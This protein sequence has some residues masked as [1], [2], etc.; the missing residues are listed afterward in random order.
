MEDKRIKLSKPKFPIVSYLLMIIFIPSMFIFTQFFARLLVFYLDPIIFYGFVDTIWNNIYVF[1]SN[2][3]KILFSN[4][5]IVEQSHIPL[6]RLIKGFVWFIGIF[7]VFIIKSFLLTYLFGFYYLSE[8]SRYEKD[9]RKWIESLD[10][11]PKN[12]I[13]IL[14][15]MMWLIT[16]L[17]VGIGT[18]Y[19]FIG[20]TIGSIIKHLLFILGIVLIVTILILFNRYK[21]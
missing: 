3:S 8:V 7:V 14:S 15:T 17:F 5:F 16:L 10:N 9:Y 2:K 1:E 6:L 4:G 21:K 12:K 13:N 20:T 11:C 19:F 18:N